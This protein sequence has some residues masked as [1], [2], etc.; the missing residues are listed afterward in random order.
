M[1][2]QSILRGFTTGG[3]LLACLLGGTGCYKVT[4]QNPGVSAGA[5]HDEWTT[6]FVFGLVGHEV[7]DVKKYCP[8]EV[9]MVRTGGNVGTT[10]VSGLT[11]G[12]YTPRKVYV[13]CA[14]GTASSGEPSDLRVSLDASGKPTEI[15]GMMGDKPFVATPVPVEGQPNA[16]AVAL[17]TEAAR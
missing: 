8:G 17:K 3:L 7:I 9:A 11:F 4:F 1:R 10:L 13:T 6:F 12:I 5:E 14:A 2:F 15:T 16:F